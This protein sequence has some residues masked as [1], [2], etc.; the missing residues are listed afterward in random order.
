MQGEALGFLVPFC[1][2]DYDSISQFSW[3]DLYVVWQCQEFLVMVRYKWS[4]SHG[5]R[6]TLTLFCFLPLFFLLPLSLLCRF[7]PER[8]ARPAAKAS[9]STSPCRHGWTH[10]HACP[11]KHA[12]TQCKNLTCLS[13]MCFLKRRFNF[14]IFPYTPHAHVPST[15][16]CAHADVRTHSH[17][18]LPSPALCL[19]LSVTMD[20]SHSHVRHGTETLPSHVHTVFLNTNINIRMRLVCQ[21]SFRHALF[22]KLQAHLHTFS[23]AWAHPLQPMSRGETVPIS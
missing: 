19:S 20:S 10:T 23:H 3:L 6:Q 14:L 1:S 8:R 18:F 4:I 12:H 5:G 9:A 21:L 7:G 17:A 22:L 13:L 11:H 2:I 16:S 15:F